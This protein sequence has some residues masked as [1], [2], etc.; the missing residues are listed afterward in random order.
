MSSEEKVIVN[1]QYWSDNKGNIY[2]ILVASIVPASDRRQEGN[3]SWRCN[4]ITS[5]GRFLKDALLFEASAIHL[6]PR[7]EAKDLSFSYIQNAV[8]RHMRIGVYASG[9][10][11]SYY[12]G[13]ED[14]VYCVL[15]PDQSSPWECNAVTQ[16][17][18]MLSGL[19]LYEN[20]VTKRLPDSVDALQMCSCL[21][22]P[23]IC[24]HMGF[25]NI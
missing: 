16:V 4:A 6:L 21:M 5:D 9:V 22:Q 12:V 23:V 18:M 11:H 13:M 10:N 1:G 24:K 19:E 14:A 7:S 8:E 15:A 17:G 20:E 25:L 2:H 3:P